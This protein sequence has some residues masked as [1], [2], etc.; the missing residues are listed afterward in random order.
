MIQGSSDFAG[1][2]RLFHLLDVFAL[3]LR[4]STPVTELAIADA[5]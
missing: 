2:L 4:T 1:L 5:L 3:D